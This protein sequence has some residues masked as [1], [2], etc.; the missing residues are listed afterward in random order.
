M[1]SGSIALLVSEIVIVFFVFLITENKRISKLWNKINK[2]IR[3]IIYI[4]LMIIFFYV[5]FIQLSNVVKNIISYNKT[6]ENQAFFD[7]VDKKIEKE[8]EYYKNAINTIKTEAKDPYIPEGF[9]HVEGEV[10]V[11]YVIEDQDK[12]QYVWIPCAS[13][14]NSNTIKLSKYQILSVNYIFLKDLYDEDGEKFIDS[15][16][17]NGGFY[18]SRYELGIQ[19]E[20]A[21]SKANVKVA[22]EKTYD[23]AK[24]YVSAMYKRED[25]SCKLI[26]GYAYDTALQWLL[27]TNNIDVSNLGNYLHKY[28]RKENDSLLTGRNYLNNVADFFDNCLEMSSE[29]C[30]NTSV[31]RGFPFVESSDLLEIYKDRF[32]F[33][34]RYTIMIGD[35]QFSQ[36]DFLAM[37]T[38]LYKN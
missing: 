35:N 31:I 21:V 36:F 12:N 20:K 13:E 3:I 27:E 37:R 17:K 32:D 7:E 24:N 34:N 16:L 26:N 30:Y 25:I 14:N 22:T 19:G 29:I 28:D 11:G 18:I 23:E 38:M 4:L 15:S 33:E 1:K 10:N 5:I 9:M 6:D 2:K 8:N